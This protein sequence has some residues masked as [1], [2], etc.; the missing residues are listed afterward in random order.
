[1]L[2]REKSQSEK[3]TLSMILTIWY[4]RKGKTTE[5]RKRSVVSQDLGEGK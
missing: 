1:M 2:L 3:A 4:S 5:I